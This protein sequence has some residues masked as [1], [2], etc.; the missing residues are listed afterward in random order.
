MTPARSSRRGSLRIE[1]AG[2]LYQG[3]GDVTFFQGKQLYPRPEA[4]GDHI[5]GLGSYIPHHFFDKDGIRYTIKVTDNK[6]TIT[7][8]Q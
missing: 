4:E 1:F 6:V 5:L 2:R 3:G 7:I 8:K